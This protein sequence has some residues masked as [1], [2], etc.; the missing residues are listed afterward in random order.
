MAVSEST[1]PLE[2]SIELLVQYEAKAIV[3]LVRGAVPFDDLVQWGRLGALEARSRF[4]PRRGVHFKHF[5][6]HRVRGA[7]F[8]GLRTMGLL[9][10]RTYHRLR[11]EALNEEVLGEPP[12]APEGGPTRTHDAKIAFQAILDL[13]TS[14]LVDM[15]AQP[16]TPEEAYANEDAIYKVR[17]AMES[18]NA[19]ERRALAAIYD[20]NETGDTGAQ[21]ARRQGTSRSRV[22]RVHRRA[23]ER[24]RLVLQV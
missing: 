20:F 17:R 21:M 1:A 6:R 2:A 13:A 18:L 10:R 22:S 12:P 7:I 19:E 14:R 8:D 16:D 24:L 4:D 3:K 9:S 23:L 11:E 5:A 15:A